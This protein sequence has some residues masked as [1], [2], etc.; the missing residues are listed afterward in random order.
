MIN[1]VYVIFISIFMSYD[2]DSPLGDSDLN[3]PVGDSDLD[4]RVGDSDLPVGDSTTTLYI[5]IC[6][7]SQAS[8]QA[9]KRTP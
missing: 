5:Y 7:V 9:S 4:V 3:L 6:K 2:S 1:I 8:K